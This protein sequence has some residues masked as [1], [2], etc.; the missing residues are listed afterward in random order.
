MPGPGAN[1][2]TLSLDSGLDGE[3][4][5]AGR[6]AVRYFTPAAL[7]A[8]IASG[9]ITIATVNQ[10]AAAVLTE[11]DRFG[12]LGPK[13]APSAQMRSAAAPATGARVISRTA[14]DAATLLKDSGH[15]LPL[16]PAALGSL[17][18]IGPGAD[19]VIGTGPPAGGTGV[20]AAAQ[21]PGALQVLR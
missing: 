12:L 18:L 19:Q 20:G 17:A 3:I 21:P 15:A 8:A 1:P 10:A 7:R 6:A 11:M 14:A 2:G 16:S 5:T 4:P 13:P 9:T